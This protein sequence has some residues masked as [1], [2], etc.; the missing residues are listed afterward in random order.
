MKKNFLFGL[1]ATAMLLLTTAC[2]KENDLANG[3]E[4]MVNFEVSAPVIA[5]RA[6]SDG[7][8]AT[9]L[10]YAV[11]NSSQVQ[12]ATM[13]FGE[14]T[15]VGTAEMNNL[16]A[17]V[18]MRLALGNTYYV[19]FWAE[20]DDAPYDVNF[21]D[22]TL[23]VNYNGAL[24]NDEN[25]DAFYCW[26]EVT[27]EELRRGSVKIEMRRP[28]AQLN[29]GTGDTEI[30]AASGV[31]V[32]ETAVKVKAYQTMNFSTG[33]VS[34]AD[35]AGVQ[36]G[37]AAK[38]N[39]Q[40]FPVANYDYLAMNYL[41]VGTDKEVVNEVVFE[42]TG[43]EAT[44]P[45]KRVF[46]SIPLRRNYRTN[47][48]GNLLTQAVDFNVEIKPEY[49]GAENQGTPYVSLRNA[50]GEYL[51]TNY[52]TIEEALENVTNEYNTIVLNGNYDHA[53]VITVAKDKTLVI[54]L[55]GYTLSGIDETDKNYG[56]IQNNGNLT[57]TGEGIIVARATINSG[58]NRYSAVISN[59]PG[60]NLTVEGGAVIEHLG[61]TDMAYGIDNL[62][63][64]KGTYAVTTIEDATI[65]ST[66]S[67]I[68]QFLNGIEATNE[69]YVKNGATLVSP[70][71]AIFFQDPSKN[72]NTGK[73]VVEAGAMVT[74]EVRLSVTAG[75][76]EWPVEISIAASAIGENSLKAVNVP[77]KYA[78]VNEDGY[79]V[80]RD[81]TGKF[82]SNADELKALLAAQ[83]SEIYLAAGT[84]IE[85]TFKVNHEVA[86][87]SIDP[88]NKSTIKGRMNLDVYSNTTFD[89]IK[90]EVNDAS[91][92]KNSF[93]SSNNFTYP[94]IVV[95]NAAAATFEGCEFADIY[96]SHNVVAINYGSHA[97]GKMLT[98]NNCKFQGYA[99]AIRSRANI[100]ITNC[101]FDHYHSTANPRAVFLW[102]LHDA[103]NMSA[104]DGIS[105]TVIF[106]G[107]TATNKEMAAVQ[108]PTSSYG[109]KNIHFNIQNNTNFL[110]DP[111]IITMVEGKF[112]NITFE[113]G[114]KTFEYSSV[115]VG[116][117]YY[118]TLQ[119]AVNAASNGATINVSNATYDVNSLDIVNKNLTFV[120]SNGA[121]IKGLVY[122]TDSNVKFEGFTFTNPDAVKTT[123]C[124]PGDLIDDHVN[125]NKPV[126]GAYVATTVAFEDCHFDLQGNVTYGF[127]GYADNNVTF[128][129]CTFECY[130]KRPIASNGDK[131]TVTGCEFNNQYH[132]S[133]RLFENSNN[134]QTVVYTNN[135]VK[136]S[137]DK[138]EFEGI[139][140][141]RKGT[142]ATILADF[143]IKDNTAGL[144]Y[145]YHAEATM[146]AACTYDT[147]GVVF[148][149]EQ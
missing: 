28:F 65:K 70:N 129:G 105:G 72:P 144:K 112:Q 99:Y 135:V 104:G 101:E 98:I 36:F 17:R 103:T 47:I 124:T 92:A 45:E 115:E 43:A 49:L 110:D 111:Y 146:S 19:L 128:D 67:A 73:L 26:K 5:T 9:N 1:F 25:R 22:K 38:P 62:T 59:N 41:L 57:V 63:N 40:T 114:S 141:S 8:T 108:M 24:S 120:A 126:V 29:I 56:L 87:K 12:L 27:D 81:A 83:A 84:T 51:G 37:F 76:T 95:I 42:Y 77:A 39:G 100:S 2:Q 118:N 138:G 94:A 119:E 58:W 4:V 16:K 145:R 13:K 14:Q 33:E 46:T 71:R 44:T 93:T 113:P 117:T 66:Y 7:E 107:N 134:K 125:G 88:T 53:N 143:T 64:G 122:L 15:G 18:S 3:N 127:W 116:G 91:K 121:T 31:T 50:N 80:K 35:E 149:Q 89:N 147:D 132:Y 60:A 75:S 20:A 137:N 96:N 140:F 61:G 133:V 54:D 109:W 32:R 79:W 52:A 11:Y 142:P 69:L 139:N 74:G 130:K 102:G 123:A 6:Y 55:N 23:T 34:N 10:Q 86:I 148:V 30:A 136:G 48:Y 97:Q 68:R 131:T 78:V 82:A 21:A 90:F 106:T 85:G